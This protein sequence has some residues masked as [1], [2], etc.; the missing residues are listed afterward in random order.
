M[1]EF[2]SEFS[3]KLAIRLFWK[4]LK[5]TVAI[6]ASR[7]ACTTSSDESVERCVHWADC[8]AVDVDILTGKT[9]GLA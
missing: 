7:V 6:Q 1:Q 4:I 3:K 2:G 9:N 8:A 5:F